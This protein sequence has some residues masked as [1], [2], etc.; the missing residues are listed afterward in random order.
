[1]TRTL[2]SISSGE[3][4]TVAASIRQDTATVSNVG[5]FKNSG[6][7]TA[8]GS[9]LTTLDTT[10][11]SIATTNTK[12]V[13]SGTTNTAT[14]VE[15]AGFIETAGIFECGVTKR[16]TVDIDSSNT[17]LLFETLLQA[18]ATDIDASN[19]DFI[20]GLFLEANA[21]D[22]S[23]GSATN[24]R[25]RFLIAGV[26]RKETTVTSGNTLTVPAGDIKES[27]VVENAGFIETAGI[28]E[29]YERNRTFDTDSATTQIEALRLLTAN[30]I[31]LDTSAVDLKR[32]RDLLGNGTDITQGEFIFKRLRLLTTQATDVTRSEITL[33]TFIELNSERAVAT[34]IEILSR[35]EIANYQ[36]Q[37]P[38]VKN[39]WDV[40]Q[41]ER[42]PGADQPVEMYAWEPTS[43]NI[44][45]FSLGD[46]RAGQGSTDDTA[47][48]EVL[49]YSLKNQELLDYKDDARRLIEKYFDDNK[50]STSWQ[51]I[52]VTSVN[53]YRE[54]TNH[55]NTDYYIIGLTVKLRKINTA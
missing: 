53:D 14:L 9:E 43:K 7:N 6:T 36:R 52:E 35:D 8:G 50:Q 1:M 40:A 34:V 29:S 30:A 54:Q 24:E 5:T 38:I 17:D 12:T 45:R 23:I 13:S 28:F 19:A 3:T 33:F 27:L 49:I 26:A 37:K 42:G 2:L 18:N 10:K 16:T 44:E 22:I 48:V 55:R 39:Y 51:T 4:E 31:D 47:S 46:K 41:S 21:T 25:D 20:F 11:T 32:V 15:N